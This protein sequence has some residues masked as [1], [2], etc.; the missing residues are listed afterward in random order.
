MGAVDTG[1]EVE[2]R[3]SAHK[4]VAIIQSNY[5]PWKGY[6]DIINS[7]DEFILYDDVQYTRRDWRNRNK[8]KTPNGAIWL[9]I[10]VLVKGKYFQA[11]KETQISDPSWA[12]DHWKAIAHNY[13]RAPYFRHYSDL[14]EGLYREAGKLELLSQVNYLF[15]KAICDLLG[16]Q[17]RLSW[18]MDYSLD[19][20][21]ERTERLIQLC[22]QVDAVEY[23]SG[24]SAK[25]YMDESLIAENGLQITY[26]DYSGYPEYPQ[27]YPPYDPAVSIL[28]LIFITGK[29]A[30][31]YMKSNSI[32]RQNIQIAP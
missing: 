19:M 25:D 23:L 2:N 9:T 30:L 18:S 6:F 26:M 3:V 16:I 12:N 5:I 8:I 24:P 29:D 11:I 31:H 15:I 20:Q 17:A 14:F 1:G 7:V 27:L 21:A 28:D 22:K 32:E 10:P 4:K 13:A